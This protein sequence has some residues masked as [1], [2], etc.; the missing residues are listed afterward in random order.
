[1]LREIDARK[2]GISLHSHLSTKSDCSSPLAVTLATDRYFLSSQ[3]TGL[4]AEA[5]VACYSFALS[6]MDGAR[7]SNETHNVE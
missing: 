2:Y 4:A 6:P 7:Y 5:L 3:R 1:M